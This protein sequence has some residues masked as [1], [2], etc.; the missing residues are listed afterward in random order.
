MK[1]LH[2]GLLVLVGA[3]C[4]AVVMKFTQR[5]KAAPAPI[6]SAPAPAPAVPAAAPARV[7]PAPAAQELAVAEPKP[8]PMARPTPPARP[9]RVVQRAKARPPARAVAAAAPVN[10]PVAVARVVP[11][12]T[13]AAAPVAEP[14]APATAPPATD[15]AP[16]P[17]EGP[18]LAP[19]PKVTLPAGMLLPVRLGQSLSSERNQTGDTFTAVLDAPLTA[20][21]YVIA[22][23]GARVEGRV[24]EARQ[25][26][27]W[28]GR[29]ALFLQLN[30]LNTSDG[31]H[32]VIQTDSFQKEAHD[33]KG[34]DVGVVAAA[35]GIGAVIGA[36]AGGGKGAAIGAGA[37]GAAG[38]GGVVAT[39]AKAVTLP[40][41]T[42]IGFRLSQQ[43]ILTERLNR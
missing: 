15:A 17:V 3:L 28:S 7:Q 26:T 14:P 30:V 37:G 6:V 11:P 1:P 31:Q 19:A 9:A 22:E 23:R 12:P 36:M 32:V 20:D 43:V 18:E 34:R 8:S 25:S 40:V 5:P 33:D 35:A 24:V 38:A 27:H 13:P 42:R 39:H 41:E 29:A 4:G 16:A 10:A 21:G 2:V